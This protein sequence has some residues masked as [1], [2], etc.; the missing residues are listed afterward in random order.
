MKLIWPRL[1]ISRIP[2]HRKVYYGNWDSWE[3][4]FVFGSRGMTCSG[5]TKFQAAY[6]AI[7]TWLVFYL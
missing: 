2:H 7:R 5:D 4:T 1:E 3:A 6:K